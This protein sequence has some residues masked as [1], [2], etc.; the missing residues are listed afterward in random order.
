M[1]PAGRGH[2]A[3]LIWSAGVAGSFAL[4]QRVAND[5]SPFALNAVRF[6]LAALLLG[7][8]VRAGGG[9]LNPRLGG[10]W[11][12]AVLGAIFALYFITM[13]EGLKTASSVSIAAVLTL[14]PIMSGF[15]GWVLLRQ[16]MTSRMALALA[17]GG[18]GAIWVIFKADLQAMLA[19]ELGRGELI[20]FVGCFAHAFY[21]PFGR[22]VNRGEQP[23]LYTFWVVV[24]AAIVATAFGLS[25]LL[26]TD[27]F[28][29][30]LLAWVTIAYTAV[31]AT[32]MTASTLLYATMRL[33][34]AKVMA[35][36]Y[37]TPSWAIAWEL[38]LGGSPP[39]PLV[40]AGLVLTV[41][42]LLLLLRE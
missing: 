34:S 41:T 17:L 5:I 13:F 33:P 7:A 39:A 42:A 2:L 15:F 21:T 3:M 19:L 40:M 31:A 27:W 32:A 9:R 23:L 29:L 36:T 22:M 6:W 26:A 37:L 14:T 18:A 10:H 28:A 35:Y 24:Y 38:A 20:F 8:V 4:G 11:R 16:R 12:Y 1:T 25:D 30:P